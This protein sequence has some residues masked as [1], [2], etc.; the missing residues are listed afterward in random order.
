MLVFFMFV[1]L[2]RFKA[3]SPK[4]PPLDDKNWVK[5]LFHFDLFQQQL[6]GGTVGD[7]GDGYR[8]DENDRKGPGLGAFGKIVPDKSYVNDQ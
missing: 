8:G 4:L 1:F 2:Y 5:V 6:E 7:K 3:T